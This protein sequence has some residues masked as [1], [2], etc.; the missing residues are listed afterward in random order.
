MRATIP[1]NKPRR[2]A[3]IIITP[4]LTS[5]MPLY[6][7]CGARRCDELHASTHKACDARPENVW[8][9]GGGREAFAFQAGTP[10]WRG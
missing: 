7:D 9:P 10:V 1:Q 4:A 8:R 3:P 5:C 6:A 2:S